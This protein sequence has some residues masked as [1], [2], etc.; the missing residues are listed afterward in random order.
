MKRNLVIEV[1]RALRGLGIYW[2]KIDGDY[3]KYTKEAVKKFQYMHHLT[4]D[5][6]AGAN[7][8]RELFHAPMVD[9][10][11]D[12]HKP[13]NTK[14]PHD[15]TQSLRDF[16]GNVGKNQTKILLPYKMEI[17]WAPGK[18]IT[19][20]T[21]HKKIAKSMQGI[22]EDTRDFYG[23][24]YLKEIRLNQYGGCLNVRKIRGGNRYSTHSWGIAVDID[25][26]HNRLRWH[27]PRAS[28]S[29]GVYDGFWQIVENHGATSLGRYKDYDWMHFQFAHKG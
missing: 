18:Y 29:A 22:F 2:K 7:T 23:E 8:L 12:T 16:Y 26:S 21:C 4:V 24:K 5:G 20:M 28:L 15:D 6:I 14:Y 1:Q 19:H 11:T 13:S 17:A 25:P 27:T 9:R 3:G 10:Q